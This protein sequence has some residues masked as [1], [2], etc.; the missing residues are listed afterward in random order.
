MPYDWADPAA[1]YWTERRA[2]MV[3]RLATDMELAA[4]PQAGIPTDEQVRAAAEK[5]FRFWCFPRT[6]RNLVCFAEVWWEVPSCRAYVEAELA[7]CATPQKD[8]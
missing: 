1:C 8:S 4:A 6:E 7:K 3:L 5:Y 2:P